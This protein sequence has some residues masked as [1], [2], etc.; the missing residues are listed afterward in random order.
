MRKIIF[1]A[2]TGALLCIAA[3]TM[4]DTRETANDISTYSTQS[5]PSTVRPLMK[6]DKAKLDTWIDDTKYPSD[7]M[8]NSQIGLYVPESFYDYE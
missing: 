7:H 3:N 2:F 8:S 4:A 5:V 1:A 6:L